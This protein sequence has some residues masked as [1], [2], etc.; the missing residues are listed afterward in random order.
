M[1]RTI[2]STKLILEV[3]R[4]F[5]CLR[6]KLADWHP[7]KFDADHFCAMMG[8]WST[9]ETLCGLFVL[10]VWNPGYAESRGWTFNMLDF[11]GTAD[12]GNRAA[13]I[14]WLERPVWP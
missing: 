10:N 11:A 13:L 6:I 8:R 7:E 1:N 9:G 2:N 3:A 5:P 4:S 12:A 14:H